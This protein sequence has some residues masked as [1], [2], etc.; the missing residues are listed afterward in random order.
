MFIVG[1]ESV[2]S[3]DKIQVI[4]QLLVNMTVKQLSSPMVDRKYVFNLFNLKKERSGTTL[5]G[6]I[7]SI[8]FC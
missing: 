1:Y 4:C 7:N 6:G 2:G 8:T 3:L 5:A